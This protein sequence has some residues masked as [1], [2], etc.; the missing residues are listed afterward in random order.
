MADFGAMQPGGSFRAMF[1]VEYEKW[2]SMPE[3]V[4]PEAYFAEGWD[5]ILDT[6]WRTAGSTWKSLS[7]GMV[8]GSA[9][10]QLARESWARRRGL[11]DLPRCF[12][13]PVLRT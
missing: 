5:R 8:E 3:S 10:K 6:K 7:Q 1:M 4:T 9:S 13:K 12:A 11:R 2:Y